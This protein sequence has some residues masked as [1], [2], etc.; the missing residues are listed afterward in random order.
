MMA[1]AGRCNAVQPK[2]TL[3]LSSSS[4][5]DALSKLPNAAGHD[6]MIAHGLFTSQL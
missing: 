6:K 3:K 5:I 2:F 1:S 4:V